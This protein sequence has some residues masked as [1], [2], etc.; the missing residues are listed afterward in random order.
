[1]ITI[2][3]I[4]CIEYMATVSDKYFD[5][6]LTDPPYGVG[7]K[8]NTYDDSLENWKTLML[9]FIPEVKRTCKMAIFPSCSINKLDWIYKNF[10]PDWLI[11]WHKGSPGHV[12][13][14]G[15]NDF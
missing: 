2:L 10:P 7:L 14:V 11:C 4:D 3:N 15:F 6:C 8:Y 12:S 5:L 9:K 1:M 13:Y